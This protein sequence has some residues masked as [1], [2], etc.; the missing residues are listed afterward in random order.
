LDER[1]AV[2]AVVAHIEGLVVEQSAGR[3]PDL[4]DLTPLEWELLCLWH[5]HQAE[6]ERAHQARMKQLFDALAQR[7]N[8]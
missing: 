5:G 3:Q 4:K 8:G 1:D 6:F 7:D 2:N